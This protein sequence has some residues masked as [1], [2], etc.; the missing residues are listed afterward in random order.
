M[1][2]QVYRHYMK[3]NNKCAPILGWI[4]LLRREKQKKKEKKEREKVIDILSDVMGK[5]EMNRKKM[6]WK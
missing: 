2:P 3:E 1:N 6:E 5:Q 4:G